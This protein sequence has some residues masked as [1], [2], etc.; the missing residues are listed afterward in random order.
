MP[1]LTTTILGQIFLIA[2]Q[3]LCSAAR[4]IGSQILH[5]RVDVVVYVRS[6]VGDLSTVCVGSQ[7]LTSGFAK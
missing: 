1:C 4:G 2:P 7:I 5:E 3:N 6:K